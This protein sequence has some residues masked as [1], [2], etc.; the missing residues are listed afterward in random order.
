LGM[1]DSGALAPDS[2]A[3]AHDMA[4]LGTLQTHARGTEPRIAARRDVKKSSMT[5]DRAVTPLSTPLFVSLRVLRE[6]K[7]KL[8]GCEKH[9]AAPSKKCL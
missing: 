6:K 5:F 9:D 8:P 7:S 1:R 4:E 3:L 2:L